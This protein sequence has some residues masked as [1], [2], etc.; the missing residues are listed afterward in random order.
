M[1]NKYLLVYIFLVILIIILFVYLGISYV[2]YRGNALLNDKDAQSVPFELIYSTGSYGKSFVLV[3]VVGSYDQG[4][5]TIVSDDKEITYYHNDYASDPKTS[6]APDSMINLP[7]SELNTVL[8]VCNV[9]GYCKT[10]R[11]E[12]TAVLQPSV[13]N[14][15]ECR[16]DIDAEINSKIEGGN[17]YIVTTK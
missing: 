17:E 14:G 2:N 8:Q 4:S 10:Y 15:R 9:F 6:E 3:Q 16:L 12:C 5:Y 1:K 11:L 13:Y 7:D